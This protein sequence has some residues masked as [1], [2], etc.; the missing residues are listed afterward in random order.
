MTEFLDEME[1]LS[2]GKRVRMHR[3][4]YEHGTK[5]GRLLILP[6]D[7]GLEHGPV[8]FFPNPESE[9][10]D[11]QFR[12]A[13]D[14]GY[15]GI[16]L[17]LG[18][19]EKYAGKYA[20]KVPIVLK[21]NGKTRIPS[22]DHALSPMTG[23]VEDAVRIGA[24]AIGYTLYIGSPNQVADFTQFRQVK[25]DAERYGMPI[26][27][28]SY[29]RGEAIAKMGGR[30][31]LYA[32]DYAARVADELGADIVKLNVPKD[33]PKKRA[34]Q[35]SPYD[36]LELSYEERVRKV[37]KSA[38]KTKVLFSGG[39]MLGDEDLLNRARVCLEEG[40]VGLI[41]GRNLWQR[42]M[43]DA[44]EITKKLKELMTGI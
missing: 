7:Q 24:D 3:M 20:G 25:K 36:T 2:L 1:Y 14:G 8:D 21:I 30:D 26:I 9:N 22:D 37:V 40:A 12:L 44:L 41:F 42:E 23:S 43:K 35:P 15:S 19:A 38:G 13:A 11:F 34:K 5:N 10:P 28:W 27:V 29:P 31:S 17:H 16:A 32:I 39:S 6:I 4:M 18:L 33:D